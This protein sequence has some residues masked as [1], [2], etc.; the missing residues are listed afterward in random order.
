MTKFKAGDTVRC[1]SK[2]SY[3][4]TYNEEY[5]VEWARDGRVCVN[6]ISYPQSQF[7]KVAGDDFPWDEDEFVAPEPYFK[8]G[9][10]VKVEFEGEITAIYGDAAYFKKNDAH[11]PLLSLTK[12]GT[13]LPTNKRAVI[14]LDNAAYGAMQLIGGEWYE[15]GMP[16]SL[17]DSIQ[18]LADK[19][20]FTV[21]HEGQES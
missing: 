13:A 20:G 5:T 12:L 14:L 3:K 4:I 11:A 1:V 15:S 21:I 16:Q 7:R 17:N 6:G 2:D 10:R 18:M 19:Y 8:A 9:D